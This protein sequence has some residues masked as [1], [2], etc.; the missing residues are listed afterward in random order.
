MKLDKTPLMYIKSNNMSLNNNFKK[1]AMNI[2]I[3]NIYTYSF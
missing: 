2:K 3:F 1:I